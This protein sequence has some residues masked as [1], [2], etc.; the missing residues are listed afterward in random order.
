VY[1]RGDEWRVRSDP[2]TERK[3]LNGRKQRKWSNPAAARTKQ[4]Q[5]KN[6]NGRKTTMQEQQWLNSGNARQL[7][8]EKPKELGAENRALLQ[9]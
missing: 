8:A 4:Q 9:S 7:P 5:F 6:R 2:L 3:G 1:F